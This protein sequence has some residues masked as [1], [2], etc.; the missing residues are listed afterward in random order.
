MHFI[1]FPKMRVS[2]RRLMLGRPTIALE[3]ALHRL[4][5]LSSHS[6]LDIYE[7][8][9]AAL[10]QYKH[11]PVSPAPMITGKRLLELGYKPGPALGNRI[12]DCYTRQLE[13]AT[14]DELMAY[15]RRHIR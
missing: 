9:M 14:E 15:V 10:E 4:D 8:A 6:R 3:L 12:K 7:A 11:E 2:T 13:G 1:E 5:C